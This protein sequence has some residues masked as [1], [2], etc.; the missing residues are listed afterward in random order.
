VAADDIMNAYP[1]S[2][3]DFGAAPPDPDG[4]GG[5]LST[6]RGRLI[7]VVGAVILL[8]LVVGAVVGVFLMSMRSGGSET[9]SG[10]S[11]PGA[12]APQ[13]PASQESTEQAEAKIPI[14]NDDVFSFRD[15]FIAL[16]KPKP[17]ESSTTTESSTTSGT[18]EVP[19]N[20]SEDPFTLTFQDVIVE[21]SVTKA[22]LYLGTTR[23][24]VAE[25]GRLG[26]TP[27]EVLDI[28]D[29]ST[30][31]MLFG[32]DRVTLSVGQSLSK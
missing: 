17:A 12:S 31:V 28:P 21:D 5:F 30:V 26:E 27:W 25:G 11:T 2:A 24:A 1:G 9:S 22:V 4:S 16:I 14:S 19:G 20:V 18:T 23:Y 6:S 10:T 8:L 7:V 32:D 29:S 13:V 15:P 3:P